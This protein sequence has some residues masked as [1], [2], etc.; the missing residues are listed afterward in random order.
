[1]LKTVMSVKRQKDH[2]KQRKKER[3][4]KYHDER[5]SLEVKENRLLS[6]D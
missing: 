1:M 5:S 6:R 4:G 3:D 2:Y